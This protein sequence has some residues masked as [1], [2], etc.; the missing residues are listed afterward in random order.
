MA[1]VITL[2]VGIFQANC[3]LL[4]NKKE[5][6]MID[7]G[8]GYRK[9]KQKLDTF[10]EDKVLAIL[11]THGHLD[12]IGAVDELV[13]DYHCPVY[14]SKDDEVLAKD[15]DLNRLY[16]RSSQITSPIKNYPVNKLSIGS[17]NFEIYDT[18]GHTAGSVCLKWKNYLFTGDTLFAGDVGRTDLYSGSETALKSSLK[19]ISGL[20]PELVIYPG[21]GESSSLE[22]EL[23]TN[24]YL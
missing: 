21:H 7:P 3:Y 13:K 6:V 14:L 2:P 19:L 11:L 17:F 15:P 10:L 24:K 20:D 18:P 1:E 22:K 12:H 5:I 23:L 16:E 8:G 4:F 9:I